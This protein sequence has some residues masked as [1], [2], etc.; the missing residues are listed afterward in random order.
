MLSFIFTL[1]LGVFIVTFI[2]KFLDN[3]PAEPI[4]S[5][6]GGF[7]GTVVAF[8][9]STIAFVVMC[10]VIGLVLPIIGWDL[11]FILG[12]VYCLYCWIFKKENKVLKFMMNIK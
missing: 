2:V 6:Y 10:G 7:F 11:G 3:G 9:L 4:F 8:I 5:F 1:I 12:P